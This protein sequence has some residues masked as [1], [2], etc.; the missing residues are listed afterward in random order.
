MVGRARKVVAVAALVAMTL[1]GTALAPAGAS[2]GSGGGGTFRPGAPGVGDD[3]FPL[4]GNGGYD[5]R[6][7]LL[8]VSY[9]PATDR[10]VGVAT[11]SAR[12]TQNLS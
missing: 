8:K 9:D 11:I 12:A 10:L 6:H 3:Y 4:Y 5:V 7:Y 2:T 1:L